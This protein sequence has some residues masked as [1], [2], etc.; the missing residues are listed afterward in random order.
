MVA[1][2]KLWRYD[3]RRM[4]IINTTNVKNT[5][6]RY[7][8]RRTRRAERERFNPNKLKTARSSKSLMRTYFPPKITNW[9]LIGTYFNANVV[10]KTKKNK[11][12]TV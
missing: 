8:D 9:N 11:L 4:S 3:D 1:E 6:R 10:Q 12:L 2:N 7:A 5:Y